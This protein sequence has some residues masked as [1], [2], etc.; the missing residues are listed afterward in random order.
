MATE[1][2]TNS[3]GKLVIPKSP[4]ATLDYYLNWADWL[5]KAGNDT[6]DTAEVTATGV[7][8]D[9]YDIVGTRV[10][11]WVSGG[12]AGTT[13]SLTFRVTT[14]GGR[15]DSRSVYLKIKAR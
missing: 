15:T 4:G 3:A 2:F 12:A 11:A 5:A 7:T 6:L 1:T 14:A 9:S 13:A 8:V 10:R